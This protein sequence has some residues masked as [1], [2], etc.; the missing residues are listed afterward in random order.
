MF[1]D[2]IYVHVFEFL[3]LGLL[4]WNNPCVLKHKAIMSQVSPK[5]LYMLAHAFHGT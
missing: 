5:V 4:G 3:F 1:S 2:C